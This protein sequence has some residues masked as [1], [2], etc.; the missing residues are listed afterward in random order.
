MS[1]YNVTVTIDGKDKVLYDPWPKQ[2]LFHASEAPNLLALGARGTGKSLTLR[3]DA[4][5]RCMMVPNFRALIIRRTMPELRRSHL[6]YIENEM[7]MLGGVFLHTTFTAK[8]PNGSTLVF[9]HCET[10]ADV[11]NFLSSEYGFIG[12]DELSTFSLEQ[13]L[14]ISAAA[15]A[16]KDSGYTAVVRAG[17][18]P[19]G[20]GQDWMYSWFVD[21]DVDLNDYEDYK[22]EEF[23][24]IH[25]TI[26]DNPS[27]DGEKYRAR[28]K[29][30]PKHMRKAWLDG[31]RVRAGMY[32]IDF[33]KTD[34]DGN[35]WHVIDDVPTW[36]K[37]PIFTYE[38]F[39]IY[40]AIDW[41]YSP[42]PAVCL[43]IAVL[44]NKRA[45]VF[46][47]RTWK[48]TLAKDVAIEIKKE[49][50]GMRIVESFCDP[51]MTIKEG[52]DYSIGEIFEQ[53]GIPVT[54]SIN[55]RML[56]GYS[57][58]EYLNTIIDE[59]PQVQILSPLG[60]LGC[61]EL[62]RTIPQQRTDPNDPRKLA[63]GNDHY[64]VALAYFCM[65]QAPASKDPTISAIPRWMQ[66]KSRVTRHRY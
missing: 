47:E 60:G 63:N 52:Q 2:R 66:P 16:P 55:D 40:R 12:F 30:L 10:E 37:E 51:T 5:I 53:N 17:S 24:H 50:E 29:N 9:A 39:N 6:A 54:P 4:I 13:F 27:L 31:E 11:M 7:K 26:D 61:R 58:N 62:I 34:D 42:D 18:N 15:R 3:W 57:V 56:F 46:K 22:P 44:P 43:W 36:K 41:G 8:F 35:P 45:I 33:A 49:S 21:K 32:F 59:K 28:L 38:W 23:D 14:T 25:S 65:G 20:D 48:R 19:I 1:K 64:A